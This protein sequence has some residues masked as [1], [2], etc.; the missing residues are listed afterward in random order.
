MRKI[1][2]FFETSV[3]PSIKDLW[4]WAER[5]IDFILGLIY[6][7]LSISFAINFEFLTKLCFIFYFLYSICLMVFIK[8]KYI[9][10]ISSS[11]YHLPTVEK[12]FTHKDDDEIYINEEDWSEAIIYLSCIEDYLE[13]TR[14]K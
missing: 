2:N 8:I 9:W 7:N 3:L 4:L 14:Q 10:D 11:A 5:N 6:V 12:R 13:S 1:F